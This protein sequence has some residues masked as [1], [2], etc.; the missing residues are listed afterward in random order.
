MHLIPSKISEEDV[1]C[2]E[3]QKEIKFLLRSHIV[4]Y[5]TT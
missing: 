1:T 2:E 3:L 5:I 4:L